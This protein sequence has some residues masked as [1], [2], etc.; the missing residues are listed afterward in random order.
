MKNKLKHKI[1]FNISILSFL[2]VT[3][4]LLKASDLK[5]IPV[6]MLVLFIITIFITGN[7]IYNIVNFF[8]K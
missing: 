8:R 7:I 1:I 2:I 5:N 3:L 4:F 6:A